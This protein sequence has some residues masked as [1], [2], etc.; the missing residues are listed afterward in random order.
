MAQGT[1][2]VHGSLRIGPKVQSL[3]PNKEKIVCTWLA[4]V[5][6]MLGP[7]TFLLFAEHT[8]LVWGLSPNGTASKH[9]MYSELRM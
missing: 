4:S 1:G 3:A 5:T 2:S 7:E 8:P 6:L 9:W